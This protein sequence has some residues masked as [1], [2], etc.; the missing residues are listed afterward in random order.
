APMPLVVLGNGSSV[1]GGLS[2][3]GT[4]LSKGSVRVEG[5]ARVAGDIISANNVE[6]QAGAVVDGVVRQGQV[7]TL[8]STPPISGSFPSS[9][10]G[11]QR[12]YADSGSHTLPSG[13]YAELQLGSRSTL[14]LQSGNYFFERVTVE[15][16]AMV[17]TPAGLSFDVKTELT[18]RGQLRSSSGG[19][20]YLPIKYRGTN[21]AVLEAPYYG[22]VLAPNATLILGGTNGQVFSGKYYAKNMEIRSG[23][24]LVATSEPPTGFAP[25]AQRPLGIE[26]ANADASA[27]VA[28]CSVSGG[29]V[30][31][32]GQWWLL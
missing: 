18:F 10:G 1:I 19:Q 15:P 32:R 12:Y 28:G 29:A 8:P 31:S 7:L 3:V 21:T 13:C 14:T 27:E 11:A 16:Q 2:L 17:V 9:C 30:G 25:Q 5:G 22:S 26:L 4:I 6:V 23:I 20:G 24:R